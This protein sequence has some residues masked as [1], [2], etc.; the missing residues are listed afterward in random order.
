MRAQKRAAGDRSSPLVNVPPD[1]AVLVDGV[2]VYVDLLDY[3]SVLTDI[4]RETEARHRRALEFLHTHYAASDGV[5]FEYDAQRVDFHGSRLHAIIVTPTGRAGERERVERALEF[6]DAMVRIIQVVGERVHNGEFK[7]RSRIGIDTGP[8]VAINSGRQ[9]EQEPLFLGNP[10]NYA[11][12]LANGKEAGIYVSD[13]VRAVL[14]QKAAGGLILEKIFSMDVASVMSGTGTPV[15]RTMSDQQ[16]SSMADSVKAAVEPAIRTAEFTFHRHEPPLSTIDYSKLSPSRTI[17]MRMTSIFAD[18]DGFTAYVQECIEQHRIAEMVSNLHVIRSELDAVL[19]TDF[20]GQ[21]VRFIGDC[22]HG[23]LAEGTRFET[24][25]AQSVK[26][27]VICAG[28]MRSSFKLCQTMLPGIQKLGLAIGIELGN[29]PVTRLGIRGDMSV[30]CATS[31]AVTQSEE[32]Q[33]DCDGHE[34]AIGE[35]ALRVASAAI[36]RAFG[37]EGK[38]P[39]LDYHSAI[40]LFTSVATVTAASGASA[41]FRPYGWR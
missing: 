29:T 37:S 11:A 23:L 3:S 8:A 26:S 32:L 19:K 20:K 24:D 41:P 34:T 5:I 12:K 14:G 33:S 10:A 1:R 35:K 15:L 21:K 18:I 28:A 31:R 38:M 6:A 30:R 40:A 27:S 22:I 36:K 25:E 9:D 16:I 13:R 17:H 7:T 4:T 39:G 2:H